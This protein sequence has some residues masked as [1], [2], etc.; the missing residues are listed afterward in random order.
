MCVQIRCDAQHQLKATAKMVERSV[1]T[2]S[3]GA[4]LQLI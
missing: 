4:V 2:R 1:L 3:H